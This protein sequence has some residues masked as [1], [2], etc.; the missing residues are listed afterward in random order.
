MDY[1]MDLLHCIEK[2]DRIEKGKDKKAKVSKITAF[3]NW[4]CNP[5]NPFHYF[6]HVLLEA[7]RFDREIRTPEVHGYPKV[8]PKRLLTL[9]M[10]EYQ[11][12]NEPL[13]LVNALTNCW[14]PLMEILN[15]E[16]AAYM[17]ISHNEEDWFRI[18]MSGDKAEVLRK[19]KAMLD[20]IH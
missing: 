10:P 5:E 15:G 17:V 6:A 19:L 8:L 4:L 12:N 11:E 3:R 13:R 16:R 7:Y 18:Y 9:Q 20:H 2:G 1:F 14:N